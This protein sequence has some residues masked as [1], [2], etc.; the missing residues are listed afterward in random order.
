MRREDCG[1]LKLDVE[2]VVHVV[3]GQRIKDDFFIDPVQKLGSERFHEFFIDGFDRFVTVT[4]GI[5]DSV[6]AD[7]GGHD[8]DGI[9]E[10]DDTALGVCQ[11]TVIEHLEQD[12]EDVRVGF[13]DFIEKNDGVGMPANG[14]GQL[15]TFIIADI[16][17]RGSNKSRNGVLLH[18]L[19]HVDTRHR[20]VIVEEKESQRPRQ[21]RFSDTCW[22]ER[23]KNEPIGRLGS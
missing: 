15:S 1:S 7:V 23:N 20:L 14:L 17:G 11:S 19:G 2:N 21:L 6:R 4:A 3:S 18:V 8:H 9:F 16:S 22:T 5:H 13:F 10:V 12:V